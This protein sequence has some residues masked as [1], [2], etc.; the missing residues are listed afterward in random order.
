MIFIQ[1]PAHY[2]NLFIP[3]VVDVVSEEEYG[4]CAFE[5]ASYIVC[6]S[7]LVCN[8]LATTSELDKRR[9]F[10]GVIH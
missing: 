10:V 9:S 8:V 5:H 2:I 4:R 1:L 3:G 6:F 7:R